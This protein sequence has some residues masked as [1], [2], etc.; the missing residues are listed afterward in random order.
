[1]FVSGRAAGWPTLH[2]LF[3]NVKYLSSAGDGLSGH[4]WK[5]RKSRPRVTVG[6][7]SMVSLGDV[8][9]EARQGLQKAVSL[10][11]ADLSLTP[12][13]TDSVLEK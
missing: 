13:A 1:V 10:A 4:E 3:N 7:E 9:V 6:N 12:D 11:R 2:K 5:Q 8:P